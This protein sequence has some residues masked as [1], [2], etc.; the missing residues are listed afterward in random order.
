VRGFPS[1][2]F[3]SGKD[4]TAAIEFDGS[5]DIEG[6]VTFLKEHAS[7]DLSALDAD[8]IEVPGEDE[9]EEEEDGHAGHDHGDA[10]SL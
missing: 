9:E 4:K 6:F 1:I 5:R 3:F 8:A 7:A 2:F 10:D